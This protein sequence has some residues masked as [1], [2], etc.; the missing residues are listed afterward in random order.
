MPAPTQ[1]VNLVKL[2]VLSLGF[3]IYQVI[4][5]TYLLHRVGEIEAEN[6]CN[7][8]SLKDKTYKW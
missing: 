6:S 3:I 4:M 2:V 8:L 5:I 1:N 7:I